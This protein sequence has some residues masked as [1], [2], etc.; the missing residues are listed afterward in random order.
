MPVQPRVVLTLIILAIAGTWSSALSAQSWE[1]RTGAD[2]SSDEEIRY[3]TARGAGGESRT[4][5]AAPYIGLRCEAR[6]SSL[7]FEAQMTS[8]NAADPVPVSVRVDDRPE[9]T[10]HFT[11]TGLGTGAYY[12]CC[13]GLADDDGFRALIEDMKGGRTLTLLATDAEGVSWD[14]SFPLPG[15]T[16]AMEGLGCFSE[17]ELLT[18]VE[19]EEPVREETDTAA[20]PVSDA[21]ETTRPSACIDVPPSLLNTADVGRALARHYPPT[22]RDARIGGTTTLRVFVVETGHVLN[23][24][25]GRS[26]G[27]QLF[28]EAAL[29]VVEVMRFSPALCGGEPQPA[30]VSIPIVF[31][32]QS[33]S[34][35]RPP[36]RRAIPDP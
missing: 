26:S 19:D 15:V 25:I 5:A 16:H 13:H 30:W 32:L 36:R 7:F 3:A 2:V 29:R 35:P 8:L 10:F 14:Y 1:V 6:G 27:H 24:Q 11:A 34:A 22:L 33:G 31:S 18:S 20:K 17:A 23:T 21:R 4:P 9:R 12:T 28:D